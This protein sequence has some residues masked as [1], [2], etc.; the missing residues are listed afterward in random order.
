MATSNSYD[1][2][3]KRDVLI[4]DALLD[5]GAVTDEDTVSASM[6]AHAAR[7]LNGMLKAYQSKGLRM[8]KAKRTTLILQKD[9]RSYNLGATGDHFC[10]ESDFIET[11]IRVAAVTGAT[12][13][14]V[15]STAGMVAL[16]YIG[17]ELDSGSMH[18]TTIASI[19]DSDTLVLTTGLPSASAVDKVIY[20]YTTKAQRP[21]AIAEWWIRTKDN[22]DRPGRSPISR[23]E[24]A[25]FGNKFTSGT[26]NSVFYDPQLTNGVLYVFQ[27]ESTV[28]NTMEL[29]VQYPIEDMDSAL[30]DFDCPQE[31]YM[32][33]KYNLELALC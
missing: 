31:W 12:I 15:N 9:Q 28:S 32:A 1:Y 18:F 7:Q 19:T 33:I 26:I 21:L 3:I 22:F 8:W 27:P 25:R 6:N 20:T 10:L 14:E 2:S 17:V 13:L 16:D 4:K 5:I 11:K 24:Y 23:E 29:W 30:N